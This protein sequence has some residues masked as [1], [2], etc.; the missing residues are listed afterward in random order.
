MPLIL[1]A[2]MT[3]LPREKFPVYS[4]GLILFALVT[5][6]AFF[7]EKERKEKEKGSNKIKG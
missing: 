2:S 1:I 6:F 4:S 5:C 3:Q 7:K